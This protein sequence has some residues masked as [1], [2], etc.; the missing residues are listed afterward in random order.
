[1]KAGSRLAAD[2]GPRIERWRVGGVEVAAAS[3]RGRGR[4]ENQDA[5][6]FHAGP[7]LRV[8]LFDGVGGLPNGAQAAQAAAGQIGTAE[9]DL[10][11]ALHAAVRPTGGATTAAIAELHDHR[12]TF[13]LIGDSAVYRLDERIDRIGPSHSIGGQLTQALGI[14]GRGSTFTLPFDAP[15]VL[16]SDGLPRKAL[17]PVGGDLAG[18]V[19]SV[20]DCRDEAGFQDDTTLVLVRHAADSRREH[21][22]PHLATSPFDSTRTSDSRP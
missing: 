21:P 17:K 14:S 3:M 20:L 4:V 12:I 22:L 18:W 16:A 5:Y 19:A 1:M 2:L 7:P 9:L 10:V 15:F 8:G 13:T 6:A 11:G